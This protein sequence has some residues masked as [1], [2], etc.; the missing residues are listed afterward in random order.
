MRGLGDLDGDSF[1]DFAISTGE[2]QDGQVTLVYGSEYPYQD[3]FVNA[4]ESLRTATFSTDITRVI[5]AGKFTTSS[6]STLVLGYPGGGSPS[7]ANDP[8]VLYG[9]YDFS[10]PRSY[11][12]TS[13]TPAPSTA[14][15][16]SPTL[17][18]SMAPSLAPTMEYC[19]ATVT[20]VGDSSIMWTVQN[21]TG[22]GVLANSTLGAAALN[23]SLVADW[24]YVAFL[25]DVAD[26]GSITLAI[27]GGIT[28]SLYLADIP[29]GT[30]LGT[31]TCAAITA[32]DQD[33][34]TADTQVDTASPAALYSVV[35]LVLLLCLP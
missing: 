16:V 18:P 26:E 15:S 27:L 3:V 21:S 7:D 23:V 8:G 1:P 6:A 4:M 13:P 12:T 32:P 11:P 5:N 22:D 17:E 20:S 19:T 35:L 24:Q 34:S 10:H 28:E 25:S 33:D 31:I 30:H 14:P 2:W 29:K 9:F